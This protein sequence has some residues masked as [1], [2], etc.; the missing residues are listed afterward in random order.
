LLLGAGAAGICAAKH[1]LKAGFRVTVFES[2]SRIGGLWVYENDNERSPAYLSLHINSEA[3]VTSYEDFPFPQGTSLYPTHFGIASYL[4]AYADHFGVRPHI[5]FRTPVLRVEPA[6]GV[7]GDRWRVILEGGEVEH[8]SDVVVATGHQG[9]P[10]HPPYRG[11]FTGEYLHSHDYRVPEPFRDKRVVVIGVGNSALDIASDICTVTSTTALVARSPVLIMPRML[12][13]V[14]LARILAKVEKPWV[15]WPVARRVR[16]LL[17]RVAFGPMEQWGFV[18]PKRRTHP[19]GHPNVMGHI[20]W[21]RITVRP[22]IAAVRGREVEFVDGTRETFDT[23]IAAT[24]YEVDLPFLPDDVSPVRERSVELYRRIVTPSWPGLYFIGFFNVSGGANIRMMD[25]QSRWL[26]A[27]MT[28]RLRLP[29]ERAMRAAIAQE[30]RLLA[31]RYPTS[32]RYGLELDPR[33]YTAAVGGDLSAA[34][35]PAGQLSSPG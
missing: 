6:E 5:R 1:L 19:A 31:R 32:P 9:V 18:T 27:V 10:A 30:R 15:P 25:V 21:E 33:L 24:G 8:F 16:E 23:M 34:T 26:V 22:G 3:G 7:E 28:G 11:D 12:L 4:E 29:D 20:A 35:A 17:S 2:G 13:G 14:P